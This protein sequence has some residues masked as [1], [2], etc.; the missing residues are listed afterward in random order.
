M[1][2]LLPVCLLIAILAGCQQANTP[3]SLPPLTF[4]APVYPTPPVVA[5]KPAKAAATT[6]PT[7]VVTADTALLAADKR[8]ATDLSVPADWIPQAPTRPWQWIVI[9]H[10]ATTW[11]SAAIIDKWHRDRGFDELGYHFVIDNGSVGCPDG[12]IE[13]GP[14]WPKQKWGAHTKSADNR[15]NEYGIGICLVG[16]FDVDQPTPAQMQSVARLAAYLMRTYHIPSSRILGHGEIKPTDCPGRFMNV[17]EVRRL[18]DQILANEGEKPNDG[19]V[20]ST[21]ELIHDQPSN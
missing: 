16:N 17:A 7:Q 13:V 2:R 15:F 20:A 18:A 4:A 3:D 12:Q 6:Q 19:A 5:L 14:R 9:H 1:A 10:S 21:D 11:G 8:F